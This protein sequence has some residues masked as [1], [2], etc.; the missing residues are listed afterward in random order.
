MTPPPAV[1]LPDEASLAGRSDGRSADPLDR[2]ADPQAALYAS[3]AGSPW[4]HDYYQTL[5]RIEALH[6][7]LPRLGKARQPR[8][9]PLRVGQDV[10]LDF[11]PAALSSWQAGPGQVPRLGQ[12]FFGLYGPMGPLPLHLSEYARERQRSH[13]DGTLAAF[14]DVFHHRLALLFYRAW[15]EAQPAVQLD[16]PQD[17]AFTRRLSALAGLGQPGF[18]QRESLGDHARL[19]HS[20][21]L[22]G[23]TRHAEGLLKIL[24]QY[25]EVPVQLDQNVGHWLTL[26]EDEQAQLQPSSSVR[27]L[28]L[29]RNAALGRKVWDRQSRVRLQFGPL[30]L[31]QYLRFQPGAPAEAELRDWLRHYLGLS[32]SVE[33]RLVL[34]GAEVPRLR[35]GWRHAVTAAAAC[36]ASA[37]AA[38]R[39]GRSAWLGRARPHGGAQLPVSPDRDDLR[40]VLDPCPPATAARKE[41]S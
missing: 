26:A 16:R 20:G 13:G 40:L 14:A 3:L 15:A 34:R 37:P 39:L 17:D 2:T 12:R 1:P 4:Q 32:F 19:Q 38:G 10:E 18:Q 30:S 25:F 6:P 22:A 41:A 27:R 7:Q 5:R 28:V 36:P 11:A 31:A 24:R 8:Q 35:L 29:G 21:W 23:G 33:L 9:E